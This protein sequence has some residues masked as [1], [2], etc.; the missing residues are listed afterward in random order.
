MSYKLC[1]YLLQS[2]FLPQG[3]PESVS[4]DYLEYQAWDTMQVCCSP[5]YSTPSLGYHTG[6]LL[7]PLFNP[8]PG[9]PCRCVTHPSIQTLPGFL[10]NDNNLEINLRQ[11]SRIKIRLRKK[12]RQF[13]WPDFYIGWL[14]V[15]QKED[16]FCG[17]PNIPTWF[18]L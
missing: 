11:F 7:T 9:I 4:K 17:T 6:A 18:E 1:L 13:S 3:Y 8:L 14:P 5:L 16:V 12:C 2:A 15:V 10:F